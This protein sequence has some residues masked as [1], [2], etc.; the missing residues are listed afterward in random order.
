MASEGNLRETRARRDELRLEGDAIG[1]SGDGVR[2]GGDGE[3]GDVDVRR[4]TS[5]DGVEGGRGGGSGEIG[6]EAR[7]RGEETTRVSV[8]EVA[9][10]EGTLEEG[11]GIDDN[12][13][14]ELA[15]GGTR[16]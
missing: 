12:G 4:W 13:R 5:G 8:E 1:E 15:R 3:I 2:G 9:H 10:G 6:G 14:P 7:A 11:H 16:R